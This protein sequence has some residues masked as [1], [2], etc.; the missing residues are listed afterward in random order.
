MDVIE[1]AVEA[2]AVNVA[3]VRA[4]IAQF[5]NNAIHFFVIGYQRAAIAK[6]T[7][8]FL[9]NKTGCGSI[10]QFADFEPIA[11]GVDGLGVIFNH[12]QFMFIGNFSNRLH[13]RALAVQMDRDDRFG[14]V[15]DC[16]F[17]FGGI[18][19]FGY[20][21][22]IHKDGCGSR[23]PDRFRSCKKSIW[24]SNDLI[25][26]P[27]PQRH[28][29]Q[30]DG[31]GAITEPD[32]ELHPMKRRQLGLKLLKHRP[33]DVLAA[34]ENLFDILIDLRLNVLVLA[35]MSVEFNFHGPQTLTNHAAETRLF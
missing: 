14:L 9:D 19:A 23:N 3:L 15:S 31:I 16:R 11:M 8:V 7:Q 34:F 24:M 12:M 30:P 29:S 10:T 4:M 17:D 22:T 20:R 26:R 18:D 28:E 21:I 6:G 35:D 27:Y 5:A 13:I 2:K 25:S 33:H 32:R 1:P